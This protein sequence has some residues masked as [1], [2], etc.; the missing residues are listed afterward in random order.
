MAEQT[1][2]G[3]NFGP[4]DI[5]AFGYW[6]DGQALRIGIR[7]LYLAG[8]DVRE[9]PFAWLVASGKPV[10]NPIIGTG[11]P[12]SV[13]PWYTAYAFDYISRY[14]SDVDYGKLK[15]GEKEYA[16]FLDELRKADPQAFE[17]S[18]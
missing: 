2:G 8:Y 11:D 14:Y 17:K 15:R 7:Q 12:G 16:A 9:A 5:S 13:V 10:P 6:Q 4:S 18:K 1:V 3:I